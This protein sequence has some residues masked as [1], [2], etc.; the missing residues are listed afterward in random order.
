M[1]SSA[2]PLGFEDWPLAERAAW[3][4]AHGGHYFYTHRH[5]GEHGPEPEVTYCTRCR[6]AP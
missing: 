2:P 4:E 3:C 5:D 6:V 1:I